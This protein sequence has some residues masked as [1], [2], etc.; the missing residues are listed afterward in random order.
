[1]S[2]L[3]LTVLAG[4]PELYQELMNLGF[5]DHLLS[6]LSHDNTDISNTTLELLSALTDT[7]TVEIDT[8]EA[9]AGLEFLI[10]H[11]VCVLS[12]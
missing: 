2:Y 4:A 8:I 11:L 1:L 3:K 12:S 6:L 5:A 10:K 7:E 9:K